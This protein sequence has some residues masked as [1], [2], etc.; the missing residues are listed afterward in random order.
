MQSDSDSD[1][2]SDSN[3]NEDVELEQFLNFEI[4]SKDDPICP[5]SGCESLK[6][7]A[8]VTKAEKKRMGNYTAEGSWEVKNVTNKPLGDEWNSSAK[9]KVNASNETAAANATAANATA[10]VQNGTTDGSYET[11]AASGCS[12]HHT[13]FGNCVY[14]NANTTG[15]KPVYDNAYPK[16][17]APAT[18]PVPASNGTLA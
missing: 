6:A 13:T 3:D 1:G 18:F 7:P 9:A 17:D 4:K 2:S 5:S 15:I 12:K 16:V 14:A 11:A 8:N 10:L